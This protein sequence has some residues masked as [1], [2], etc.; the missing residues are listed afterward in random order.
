MFI[1]LRVITTTNIITTEEL[2]YSQAVTLCRRMQNLSQCL[3]TLLQSIKH[4]QYTLRSMGTT[5]FS[6]I[7]NIICS[8]DPL[9]TGVYFVIACLKSCLH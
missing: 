3:S 7:V 9:L 4:V 6:R 1:A 8:R 2:L 5:F